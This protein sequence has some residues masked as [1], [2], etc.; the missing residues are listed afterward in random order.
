MAELADDVLGDDP[1]DDDL[2][3]HEAGYT[4]AKQPPENVYEHVG[5]WQGQAGGVLTPGDG[6]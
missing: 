5:D 2:I 6:N 4:T 3:Y 1:D